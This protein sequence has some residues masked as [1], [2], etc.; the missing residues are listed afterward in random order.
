MTLKKSLKNIKKKSTA[1]EQMK[2]E[3]AVKLAGVLVLGLGLGLILN[4]SQQEANAGPGGAEN[5]DWQEKM[6]EDVSTGENFTFS[7]LERPVLI[8]TFAVWCT[9]CSRQ[10]Q[11]IEKLHEEVNVTSV[12]L[13]VDPN[14]DAEKVVNHRQENEFDWR[15]AVAPVDLTNALRNEFG[16]SVANPPSAPVIL[17]CDGEAV[18]IEKEGFGSPVKSADFLEER[19]R[20]V[21]G[22]NLERN[23]RSRSGT[24][25]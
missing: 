6:L 2:K 18:R 3:R 10:Q 21:C 4:F 13:N 17:L 14:E 1:S 19:I 12:S 25:S 9:T 15:Y 7:G 22:E 24:I 23:S 16:N 11:E 8:E 5:I 20:S